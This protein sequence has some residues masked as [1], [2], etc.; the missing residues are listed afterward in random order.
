MNGG[1]KEQSPYWRPAVGQYL[2][3]MRLDEIDDDRDLVIQACL[4]AHPADDGEPVDP[5]WL[6]SVG[7]KGG[8]DE[9]DVD[10]YSLPVN[11]DLVIRVVIRFRRGEIIGSSIGLSW[12]YRFGSTNVSLAYGIDDD[13][14]R[15]TVRRLCAALGIE[16]KEPK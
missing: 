4:A 1:P 12:R 13:P 2:G 11:G 14:D 15:G 16:L 5:D 3:F 9:P 10:V 8:N 6:L 7:A